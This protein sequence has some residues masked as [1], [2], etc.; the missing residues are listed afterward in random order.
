MNRLAEL[1]SLT[2]FC[3]RRSDGELWPLAS[4]LATELKHLSLLSLDNSFWEVSRE[5]LPGAVSLT[6]WSR[7]RSTFKLKESFRNDNA[8][9]L[10][11]YDRQ[12]V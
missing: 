11:R 8:E 3:M 6:P 4:D 7:H 10:L 12:Y 5:K 1:Q 9:W 2:F